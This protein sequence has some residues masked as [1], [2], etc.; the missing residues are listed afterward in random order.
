MREGKAFG[1]SAAMSAM[2]WAVAPRRSRGSRAATAV[3]EFHRDVRDVVALA[4]VVDDDDVGVVEAAGRLRLAEEPALEGL[5]FR[6]GQPDRDGLDGHDAIDQRVAGLV[7]HTH[8]A[9]GDLT[10]DLVPPEGRPRLQRVSFMP[11]SGS[12]RP[13]T[14]RDRHGMP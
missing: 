14:A 7:H 8:R 1:D 9:M 12:V 3:E 6:G 2:R 4:H 11:R 13:A 5:G 10:Q